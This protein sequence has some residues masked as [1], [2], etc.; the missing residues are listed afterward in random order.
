LVQ[1]HFSLDDFQEQIVQIEDRQHGVDGVIVLHSTAL[2]P[3]AGGCRLWSYPSHQTMLK[4][5]MRLARGMTYK[6]AVAGLPLGGGKAVFNVT[7]GVTNRHKL[8]VALADAIEALD[9]RY[10]TAEDVGTNVIDMVQVRKTTCHVSGLV[11][12]GAFGGDPSPWTA[13]TVFRSMEV[14][15]N[16]AL[17]RPLR[18]LRIAVQGLGNVGFELC[19]LLSEAGASLVVSDLDQTKAALASRQFGAVAV[20]PADIY[21]ASVDVFSPCAMGGS[22][23]DLTIGRLRA[24][25]VCGA[26]NNQLSHSECAHLLA[27]RGILFA[28]D[29]VV[30]AGGII[31]VASEH[32]SEPEK[33]TRA[34]MDG[35]AP[36]LRSILE[37]AARHNST[38]LHVAEEMARKT[39]AA[40]WSA[41]A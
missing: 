24:S 2:G 39:V 36:R 9:G 22:L 32:L 11:S 14:A 23:D 17:G 27:E 41:A 34:L 6:N 5:A 3:A 28:P 1:H 26:A 19:R 31:S 20:A 15:V 25:V 30:N 16:W 38:P 7:P 21:G 10:I 8:F 35:V 40:K 4:D 29:F 13:L 18:D 33:R 12:R 37:E